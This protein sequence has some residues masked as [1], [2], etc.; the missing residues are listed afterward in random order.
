M[1][2]NQW[3]EASTCSLELCKTGYY[4]TGTG[5]VL[6][7]TPRL[8]EPTFAEQVC[9]EAG[10]SWDA[11]TQTCVSPS[12]PRLPPPDGGATSSGPPPP[13]RV[14]PT[15]TPPSS[16]P[17]LL[18]PVVMSTASSMSTGVGIAV[19][20]GVALGL[21]GLVLLLAPRAPT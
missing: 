3:K 4:W 11:A 2:P 20:A 18:P 6:V 21:I 14:P 17:P 1:D 5:C 10:L 7:A 13:M 15:T 19:G 12:V 16:P 9:V 8:P